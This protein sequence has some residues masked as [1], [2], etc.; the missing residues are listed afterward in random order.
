MP[1]HF[2]SLSSD[3]KPDWKK[4]HGTQPEILEYIKDVTKKRDLRKHCLFHTSVEKAEWDAS[5]NVW[6]IEIRDVHTGATRVTRATALISAIGVLVIPSYPKLQGIES[7]NGEVFHSAR[8]NHDVD[9]HGKRVAVVGNGSSAYVFSIHIW[10][11]E[12]HPNFE[13]LPLSA[14]FVPKISSDP[15]VSVVNFARTAMWYIPAASVHPYRSTYYFLTRLQPHI[16]YSA[17][18]KLIFAYIP[19][20]QRIHRFMIAAQV[21]PS[22]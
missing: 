22:S 8:W 10:S 20:V 19:F 18:T 21:T 6:R 16:P 9:L 13:I 14:Q 7:F 1:I 4:S 5:A 12:C 3:L 15:T 11:F 2:Y 17:L